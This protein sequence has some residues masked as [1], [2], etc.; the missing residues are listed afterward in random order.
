MLYVQDISGFFQDKIGEQGIGRIDL[1]RTLFQAEKAH[2]RLKERFSQGQY[3]FLQCVLEEKDIEEWELYAHKFQQDFETILILGTGGSSLGGQTLLPLQYGILSGAFQKPVVYFLENV[4]PHTFSYLLKHLSLKNTGIIAISKSGTTAETMA[5]VLSCESIWKESGLYEEFCRHTLII[6]EPKSSPMRRFAESHNIVCLDHDPRVGGRFSVFSLVGLLP[7]AIA[8]VD[9]RKIRQGGKKVLTHFLQDSPS[10]SLLITAV[11]A[12]NAL[13][14][15]RRITQTVLMPYVDRLA[16]FGL[17]FR[18]LWAESLGK[19]G[20]GTTPIRAM[21]TVDQHSQL[22][23]YLEGPKDKMFTVLGYRAYSEQEGGP[24]LSSSDPELAYLQGKN[25]GDLLCAEEKATY[26]SLI[27]QGCPTRHISFD[28]LTEE[29][30]G[31]LLM[32]FMLETLLMAE[33]MGVDPLTQPAVEESKILTRQYLQE[34][35]KIEA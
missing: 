5:Q 13:Q 14:V 4:D 21:G 32:H 25:L 1:E 26:Q 6:T 2:S 29:V 16:S 28:T 7:A 17:W 15:E 30:I 20:Q 22:Q 23:L 18:Q 12:M 27:N 34:A 3:P 35:S 33:L 10:S 8:G 19:E 9:P 11:A 24:V 31:S